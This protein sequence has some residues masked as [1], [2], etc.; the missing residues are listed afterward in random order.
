MLDKET[1]AAINAGRILGEGP[2][3]VY[4]TDSELLRICSV[5]AEEIDFARDCQNSGFTPI[6]LVLDPTPFL[7]CFSQ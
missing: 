5:V 6:L 4:L 2:L 7:Q 3:S 1:R